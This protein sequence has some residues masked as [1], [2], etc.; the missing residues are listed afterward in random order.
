MIIIDD[1]ELPD[2][3][4]I[5]TLNK[6]IAYAVDFYKQ[7]SDGLINLTHILLAEIDSLKKDCAEASNVIDHLTQRFGIMDHNR[8]FPLE[9]LMAAQEG[10][11]RPHDL[12]SY[13][14]TLKGTV[15][16]L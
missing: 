4:D 10:M 15:S 6:R 11:E 1:A 14:I 16:K 2:G 3:T 7:K 8:T 9:N 12:S 13:P 5:Q